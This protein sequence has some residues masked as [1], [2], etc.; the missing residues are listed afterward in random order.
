MQDPVSAAGAPLVTIAM[1]ALN[2]AAHIADA[3]ASVLPDRDAI[4]CELLVLDGGSRDDTCAIVAALSARDPRIRLVHN[5]RRIQA[6]A[7]NLAARLAHPASAYLVRADCH[8][9]YPKGFVQ[10]LVG[11]MRLRQAVSVVVPLRTVGVTPLQRAIAA[12]QNSRLGN[13]GSAHRQGGISGYVAH[14]HHAAFDRR[15][16]LRVGGYDET[17]THNEDAELD[18]R[19]CAAGGRIYLAAELAITYFPRACLRSLARQYLHYGRGCARTLEKHASLPRARQILPA[20]VLLYAVAALPLAA[21]MPALLIPLLLYAGG[22]VLSG[23]ALALKARE[24][25]LVMSGPAAVTMHLSW[26]A[27]FLSYPGYRRTLLRAALRRKRRL[28]GLPPA[29]DAAR[30]N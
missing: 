22:C 21:L 26:A 17:F 13:G 5:E 29:S 28:L 20:L 7:I 24:P 15:E 27:G 1:P 8:A 12:A 9:V 6:A 3:I 2:E 11:T 14:G 19:L 4:A 30:V 23:L 25:V 10:N 18:R 16:F